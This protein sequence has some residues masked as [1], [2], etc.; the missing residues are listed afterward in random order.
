MTVIEANAACAAQ[1]SLY[2]EVGAFSKSFRDTALNNINEG[3]EFEIPHDYKIY[4][5][6]M[7]RGGEPVLDREGVQ[8]TAEFI[9][10]AT[11]TGRIV[12][13]YPTSLSKIAFAVDENGKDV[14]GAGRVV[15]TSGNLADFVRGKAIDDVMQ[16]LKGCTVKCEKLTPVNT[17]VFGVSNEVATAKDIQKTNV[18]TWTLVGKKKPAG[19]V[20]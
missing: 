9:N 7:M 13:F 3:E 12:R 15:S 14:V 17:R 6:R 16:S 11:N 2:R 19:W 1:G 18:G 5:Q 8:V 20:G 4:Q 10:V